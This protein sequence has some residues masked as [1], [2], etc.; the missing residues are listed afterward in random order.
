MVHRFGLISDVVTLNVCFI[1]IKL[2]GQYIWALIGPTYEITLLITYAHNIENTT[3]V[4]FD[5]KFTRQG[6]ENAC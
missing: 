6:F 1:L 4:S 3:R 5:I 2:F